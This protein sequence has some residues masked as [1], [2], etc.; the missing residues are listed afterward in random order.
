MQTFWDVLHGSVQQSCPLP[1]V[2]SSVQVVTVIKLRQILA[3][4]QIKATETKL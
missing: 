2:E 4:G 3:G 1:H